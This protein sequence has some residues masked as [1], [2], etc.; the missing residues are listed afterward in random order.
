MPRACPLAIKVASS[1][2]SFE[3][4]ARFT[5]VEPD[6]L[7]LQDDWRAGLSA[8]IQ[9]ADGAISYWALAHPPGD[10]DFHH[11]AGFALD[12]SAPPRA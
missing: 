2:E 7:P 9:A 6:L 4:R 12:V 1:A 11:P 10:A 8:V 5:I 3:L